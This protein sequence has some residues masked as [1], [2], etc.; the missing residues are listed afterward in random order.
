MHE[1]A[2]QTLRLHSPSGSTFLREMITT[3][4]KKYDVRQ[5]MRIYLKNIP[6]KF[7]SNLTWKDGVLNGRPPKKKNKMISDM[8]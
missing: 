1:Y 6:A 5:S 4:S 3:A 7:H 2:P 8:W